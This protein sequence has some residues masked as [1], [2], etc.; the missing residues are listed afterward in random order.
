MSRT[1]K[2]YSTPTCPYCQMVKSFLKDRGID[3]VDFDVSTDAAAAE[4]MVQKTGQM[5]VPV[6]DIDGETVVGFDQERI[7]GLLGN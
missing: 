1:I 5:G 2:I 6:I 4:E 7:E 3:Y